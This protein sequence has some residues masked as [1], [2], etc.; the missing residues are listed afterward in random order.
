LSTND[1]SGLG[2][3]NANTAVGAGALFSNND[4]DSNN[5]VGFNALGSNADGL[6]NDVLG[7]DAMAD[8]ISGSGNVAVGDSAGAGAEGSFNIYIGWQ[9]SPG[10]PE[11]NTIRI[12]DPLDAAC[13][14][15]RSEERR[16]GKD[17][18]PVVE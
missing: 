18:G 1:V 3:G 10:A 4:G 11:D 14:I 17:G 9:V 8:N 6:Q 5:A 16:V 15:G 7:F 2:L 13:F 12:G